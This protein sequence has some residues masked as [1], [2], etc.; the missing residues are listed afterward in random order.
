MVEGQQGDY[1]WRK[2][3]Q[4][5]PVQS[6][7]TGHWATLAKQG[8][9]CGKGKCRDAVLYHQIPLQH[10]KAYSFSF[11]KGCWLKKA[12]SQAPFPEQPASSDCLL[13]GKKAQHLYP[14]WDHSGRPSQLQS[15]LK[16][17]QMPREDSTTAQFLFLPKPTS[18]FFSHKCW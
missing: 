2:G 18:F 3:P 11:W 12:S 16:V 9:H 6:Y 17:R 4:L 15:S 10:Q 13:Q 8:S 14:R 1:G 7:W 5:W